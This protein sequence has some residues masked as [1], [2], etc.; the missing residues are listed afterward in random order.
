M[1]KAA[2]GTSTITPVLTSSA[3]GTPS[4]R[5]LSR[6]SFTILLILR[7]SSRVVTIGKSIDTLPC[8]PAR[9]MARIWVIEQLGIL[10][11]DPDR[12]PAHER[13]GLAPA[14]EIG[15]RLVTSQVER[16]NG[17]RLIGRIQDDLLVVLILFLLAGDIMVRQEQVLGP[18]ES[19][20]RGPDG[21]CRVSVCQV[22]D[23]RQQFG[24]SAI[25]AA[26]R[27]VAVRDQAVFQMKELTLNFTV[28]HRRFLVRANQDMAFP[29]VDDHEV[30]TGDVV[31]DPFHSGDGGDPA[32][33]SQDRRMAGRST[34][35]GD[36]ASDCQIAQ[37]H[38]LTRQD[39]MRH[40]DY[41]LIAVVRFDGAVAC[42]SFF[43]V[44]CEPTRKITSRRSLS[45][46]RK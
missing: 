20:T 25:Q 38:R 1:Q 45:R 30:A 23:I 27:L 24:A 11:E 15:N 21:I 5:K 43:R 4:R 17:H 18:E 36:D 22:V 39:F 6:V 40:Q 44:R 10:E 7:S 35:F 31:H 12:T 26:R 34:D 19:D 14:T 28:G 46:S 16:P 3:N 29:A 8:R 32:A 9:R 42:G 41:R 2:A 37:A 13:V 33:P